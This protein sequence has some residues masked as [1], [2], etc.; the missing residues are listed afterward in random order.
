MRKNIKVKAMSAFSRAI[1]SKGYMV[2]TINIQLKNISQVEHNRHLSETAFMLNAISGIVAY[3]L[4]D[5]KPR[6]KLS[7]S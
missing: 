2:E 7:P 5:K 6:N 1:L 3:C 4:K